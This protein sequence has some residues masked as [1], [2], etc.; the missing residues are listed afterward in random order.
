MKTFMTIFILV[1]FCINSLS[2]VSM[3]DKEISIQD[4]ANV[5]IVEQATVNFHSWQFF[6]IPNSKRIKN[7]A[8]LELKKAAQ[9]KHG[10]NADVINITITGGWSWFELLSIYGYGLGAFSLIA[11]VSNAAKADNP[12]EFG[13]QL[14]LGAGLGILLPLFAGNTQK[15]TAT[16]DIIMFN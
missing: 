15:I 2:C 12:E 14:G 10:P 8:Y 16:G 13:F 3:Q 11:G 4:R 6:H 9:E 7:K 1:L 5:Q